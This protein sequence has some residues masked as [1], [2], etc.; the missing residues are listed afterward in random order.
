MK[1]QQ[2]KKTCQRDREQ[3]KG[4]T[5]LALVVAIIIL[6]ILAGIGILMLTGE[7]RNFKQCH[8]GK[9]RKTDNGRIRKNTVSNN[10]S[11]D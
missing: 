4:I 10:R 3:E 6:L 11:I 5:L 9:R 7:N 8:K 2:D 1:K